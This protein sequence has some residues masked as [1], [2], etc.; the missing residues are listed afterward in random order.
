[1]RYLPL[2]LLTFSLAFSKELETCYKIYFWFFPVAKSCVYYTVKED[3]LKIKSWAK[4]VVMGSLVKRV[5]SWG[6]ATLTN[7]KPKS[8]S[9]FQREGDYV[10]DHFYYFRDNGISYRIVRYKRG[11][12]EIKEGFFKVNSTLFDPFSATFFVYLDTPNYK[13][14]VIEVFY[15]G[16]V[17]R[18]KYK[19]VGEEEIE[20][21]GKEFDTWKVLLIPQFDV[22]GVLKPKGNWYVWV[23]KDT[24]IPVKLK[25]RFTIGTAY[26]YLDKV[27]GDKKLFLE[28]KNE[29]ARVF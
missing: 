2:L 10:R 9:L 22:K 26:V 7:L 13:G 25:I 14:G 8:F 28:V 11:K 3:K 16:K 4:T 19:T 12:E 21:L 6:E 24:N 15:D 17:Q 29:Q 20:V 27:K 5:N 23:D 18:I 1:M